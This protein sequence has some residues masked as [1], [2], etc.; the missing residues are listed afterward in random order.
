MKIRS[1]F[2][3]IVPLDNN[4]NYLTHWCGGFLGLR[5]IFCA[6]QHTSFDGLQFLSKLPEYNTFDNT[7]LIS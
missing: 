4:A 5:V 3:E 7:F 1:S 6:V 2:I